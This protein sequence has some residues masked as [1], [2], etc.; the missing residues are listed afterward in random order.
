MPTAVRKRAR[1]LAHPWQRATAFAARV[2]Q[3]QLRKDG[4]TPYASHAYRVA[5]TVVL[6][7]GCHD[8]VAITAALLHD[9]IEDTTTDFEDIEENFGL[10]V[11]RIVAALTKSMLLPEHMREADYDVRLARADWRARLVK[12]AD[13]YDNFMDKAELSPQK[14]RSLIGKCRRAIKLAK[15][16]AKRHPESRRAITAVEGLLRKGLKK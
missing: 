15:P 2:H 13:T 9:T 1:K 3:H 6:I 10:E 4:R 12:L 14:R 16:D 8:E 11:A 5:M 7:F